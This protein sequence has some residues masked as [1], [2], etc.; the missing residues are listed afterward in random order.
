MMIRDRFRPDTFLRHL[1]IN[2]E[3]FIPS[4]KDLVITAAILIAVTAIGNLFLNLG[5]VDSNIITVY[6]LGVLLTSLFT[7]SYACSVISSVLSVILFNFFLTEPRLTLHAYGSGYPVTFIIMLAASIITGTLAARLKEHA[8]L[9]AQ[10]A[11]GTKVLLDTNRLLQQAGDRDDIIN[12]TATQLLKF[13]NRHIIVY[14][15]NDG[16]LSRGLLFASGPDSSYIDFFSRENNAAAEWVYKNGKQAGHQTDERPFLPCLYLPISLN[17]LGYGVIGIHT[18]DKA[19]DSFEENIVLSILG[20]CALA[21]ENQKNAAEK[22]T[23]AVMAKNEQLRSN[24]L[25]AISHDLRTP[26][27]SISGNAATLLSNFDLLDDDTRKQIFTDIY[28]DS[29]WLI[30]LVENLLSITRI[31]EGRL[32]FNMSIHVMDEVIE[33]ALRHI[34]QND[35]S[36]PVVVVS[37]ED[38]L[39]ARMDAK[40]IIQVIINLVDNAM[41]HTPPG[42][43]IQILTRRDGDRVSV[44]IS[45]TGPGIPDEIKPL[46][47]DM[48]Y[49]GEHPIA[50][51]RRSLG[52]GLFLCRSIIDAHGG[53]LTLTD[54]TPHGAVFTCNLPSGEVNIHE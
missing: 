12:I 27:T 17:N 23:A 16:H 32:H 33:E 22:E 15:G 48:F 1:R 18:A 39:L 9:S 5:F 4:P 51:C 30:N 35:I 10:A 46:V 45:D 44:S 47:F 13:L 11:F 8:Q 31:E 14:Q 53:T 6:L 34:N 54:N 40:L 49:T 25:R 3:D 38:L 28:D 42:T 50:D 37:S 43:Q 24:L 41:K 52:L 19:L 29:Q 26:L 20:E 21:I 7:R 2:A 36:H